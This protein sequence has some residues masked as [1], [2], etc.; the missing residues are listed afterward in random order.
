MYLSPLPFA[1]KDILCIA[2][3]NPTGGCGSRWAVKPIYF[4]VKLFKP[5]IALLYDQEN[6]LFAVSI[7]VKLPGSFVIHGV[8]EPKFKRNVTRV[9]VNVEFNREKASEGH[10]DQ[11]LE[12]IQIIEPPKSSQ[13]PM[14]EV[15]V[16]EV[17]SE[18]HVMDEKGSTILHYEDADSDTLPVG[19]SN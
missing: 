13:F 19:D 4:L 11:M 5:H 7:V 2:Q 8:Q 10:G 18:G 6:D 1:I 12:K 3:P 16:N 15:L 17:N 14:V 9:V